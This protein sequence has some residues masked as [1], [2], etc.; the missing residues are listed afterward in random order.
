MD[1]RQL[2]RLR[3][4]GSEPFLLSLLFVL[5]FSGSLLS[6]S[7]RFVA[8]RS[9]LS[10]CRVHPP[11]P[12]ISRDCPMQ[13]F[14]R[15]S[16]SRKPRD[17]GY[18]IWSRPALR[19]EV[20]ICNRITS[21]VFTFLRITDIQDTGKDEPFLQINRKESKMLYKDFS[22]SVLLQA[23]CL[24]NYD[25]KENNFFTGLRTLKKAISEKG[26]AVN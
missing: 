15:E 9:R 16:A 2:Q 7:Q 13:K 25:C 22:K 3:T 12:A 23:F 5:F 26:K 24:F 19:F 4:L 21:N 8:L 18:L 17:A 11:V 10:Q 20:R 1:V 6:L 14:E